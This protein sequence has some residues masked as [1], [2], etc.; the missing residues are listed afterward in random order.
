MAEH[1]RILRIV[2]AS[3]NDLK[4]ER[5]IVPRVVEGLNKGIAADRGLRLEV[6]RWETDTYPGFHPEGPQGLIDPILHIEDC[7]V[8]IGIFWK[9]FGT[10]T[11]DGTT[12]TEHEIRR[13]YEAW[14]K[15]QRPQ[16]MVYFNQKPSAPQSH[17]EA[18]QWSQVLKFREEFPKKGLWWP[19]NGTTH[20]EQLLRDH[21]TNFIRN[22]FPIEVHQPAL[23][24]GMVSVNSSA[25]STAKDALDQASGPRLQLEYDTAKW[26]RCREVVLASP[27]PFNVTRAVLWSPPATGAMPFGVIVGNAV[28]VRLRLSNSGNV[29]ATECSV[30]VERIEH[31]GHVIEDESSALNWTDIDDF[32][33]RQVWEGHGAFVDVCAVY[34]ED[35]GLRVLSQK[36]AKGYG[37]FTAQG[38]YVIHVSARASGS[39]ASVRMEVEYGGSSWDDLKVLSCTRIENSPS[40]H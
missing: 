36:G 16:V 29:P 22:K 9:R 39:N 11:K 7:D 33:P 38:V 27:S 5:A 20:F 14:K 28:F 10:P 32:K 30:F 37:I 19:Y 1:A 18:V 23:S 40:I 31:G 3:P 6:T 4:A 13:A 2:V 34:H 35:R 15:Q 12:G 17:G 25:V 24:P 26:Q 8:V 21:L